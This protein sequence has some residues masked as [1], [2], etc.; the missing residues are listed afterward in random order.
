MQCCIE[1]KA[2]G[3]L[4]WKLFHFLLVLCLPQEHAEMGATSNVRN[5]QPYSLAYRNKRLTLISASLLHKYEFIHSS[6]IF[7]KHQLFLSS[8]LKLPLTEMVLWGAALESPDA[9]TTAVSP[10]LYSSDIF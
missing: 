8:F 4:H 7:S 2:G 3:F 6:N 5:P 9:S 1:N 10:S